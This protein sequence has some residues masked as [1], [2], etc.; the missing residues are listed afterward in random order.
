MSNDQLAL[1]IITKLCMN[2]TIDGLHF[3]GPKLILSSEHYDS[4]FIHIE[5]GILI[6]DKG[7]WEKFVEETD[8]LQALCKFRRNK[9]MAIHLDDDHN[10]TIDFN[11]LSLQLLGQ[12]GPYESWQVEGRNEEDS[13]AVIAGPQEELIIF[14]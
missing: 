1:Q 13:I 3:W 10:L 4:L 9:I 12:N 11:N 8:K 2:Q 14:E 7:R 5:G 6:G